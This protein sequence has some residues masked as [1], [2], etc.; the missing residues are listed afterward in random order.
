MVDFSL[1]NEQQRQAITHT[2]GPALVLAG[3]G[4]GKTFVITNRIAHL[5]QQKNVPPAQIAVFTFTKA[6]ALEMRTRC[7]SICKEA[8]LAAFGTFH[9]IFYRMLL[10]DERYAQCKVLSGKEK[11]QLLTQLLYTRYS[12]LSV[13]QQKIPV[14]SE[15]ISCYLNTNC[16]PEQSM[17][18]EEFLA[19]VS[20]YIREC[21]L[22]NRLDFDLI[23]S[24]CL[25]LLTQN[26]QLRQRWQSC[27]RYLLVDEF[28]DTNN[29]Q[30]QAL[31]I[32]AQ[33]TRNLFVVGDDDQSIYSFRGADPSVML[34][35]LEH[36]PDAAQLPLLENFRSSRQVLAAADR[37]IAH[38]TKRFEKQLRGHRE[39]E[40]SVSLIAA[41]SEEEELEFLLE[42]IK[43]LRKADGGSSIAILCRTAA[44]FPVLH[45]R[46]EESGMTCPVRQETTPFYEEEAVRDV[47]SYLRY[48]FEG[49]KR[50]DLLPVL[51]RPER[52]LSA[53]YLEEAVV[54]L[55]VCLARYQKAWCM[56]ERNEELALTENV[57][58]EVFLQLKKLKDDMRTMRSLDSYGCVCYILY[59]IGYEKWYLAGKSTQERARVR[60]LWDRLKQQAKRYPN[61]KDWLREAANL[62]DE[63]APKKKEEEKMRIHLLTYHGSKGLEFD[64][65]FLPFV[66]EHLIPHKKA[67]TTEELEEERRM[68]YVAMTRA[69][70]SLT[71]SYVSDRQ[72]KPSPFAEEL[73]SSP[74][75]PEL[76]DAS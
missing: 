65:V 38:N 9:S 24:E 10:S 23:L 39:E 36:Y 64:H 33:K 56:P 40:G 34:R 49:R 8:S 30:L 59:I 53:L 68:F 48:A 25:T 29:I 74:I 6:A 5:I 46:L 54:D 45:A 28:Q 73:R 7:V 3:P 26:R 75:F 66:N 35:F 41:K 2:D 32:L 13:I 21:R 12:D 18:Q 15:G 43:S 14:L 71:I 20:A 27:F 57:D 69:R 70:D 22:R 72:K 31:G 42:K 11:T 62:P 37:F 60:E 76:F 63:E 51:N 55:D 4:C 50:K 19:F 67:H 61:V 16:L 58:N 47:L 1:C 52:F 17:E 44:R